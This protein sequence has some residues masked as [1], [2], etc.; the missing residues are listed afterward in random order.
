MHKFF[1]IAAAISAVLFNPALAGAEINKLNVSIDVKPLES[2]G[3]AGTSGSADVGSANNAAGTKKTTTDTYTSTHVHQTGLTLGIDARNFGTSPAHVR[4]DWVFFAEPAEGK[5]EPTA[6][7]RGGKDL[8]IAPASSLQLTAE[9]GEIKSTTTKH[10]SIKT[11]SGT[12]GAKT[13]SAKAT[14]THA[15]SRLAGWYVRLLS[16]GEVVQ[17]RASG[18]AFEALGKQEK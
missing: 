3:T 11:S 12:S 5:A 10:L 15:G 8:D 17:V 14:T 1:A 4:V 9:S 18:P 2:G 7:V 13:Q 16:G 6:H